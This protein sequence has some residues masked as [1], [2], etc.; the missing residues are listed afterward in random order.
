MS[1]TATGL[2]LGAIAVGLVLSLG[3]QSDLGSIVGIVTDCRGAVVPR[4]SLVVRNASTYDSRE[5]VSTESGNT[6]SRNERWEFTTSPSSSSGAS[7]I[8]SISTQQE[9]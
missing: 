8:G 3:A 1:T 9:N 5:T 7:I 4:V 2:R 6:C